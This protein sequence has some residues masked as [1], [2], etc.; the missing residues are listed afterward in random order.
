MAALE[1]LGA[2]LVRAHRYPEAVKQLNDAVAQQKAG[3]T[4]WTQLF[5]AMSHHQLGDDAKAKDFLKKADAQLKQIQDNKD[6]PP[7]WQEFLRDKALRQEAEELLKSPPAER[8][9]N[10]ALVPRPD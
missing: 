8:P 1:I 9:K 6:T 4:V 7:N 3:G 5:L 10:C 2:A